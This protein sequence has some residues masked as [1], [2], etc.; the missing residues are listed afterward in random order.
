MSDSEQEEPKIIVDSDWKEL[1]T[2]EED[3]VVLDRIRL[4][5]RTG[6]PLGSDQFLKRVEAETGRTVVAKRSGPKPK[7]RM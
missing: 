6:R 1:F 2:H 3:P 5:A 4:K 7:I